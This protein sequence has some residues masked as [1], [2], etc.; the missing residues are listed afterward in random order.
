MIKV[1]IEGMPIMKL[2][3]SDLCK[4]CRQIR[5]T[6]DPEPSVEEFLDRF[7]QS[8]DRAKALYN[9]GGN[10]QTVAQLIWDYREGLEI[11]KNHLEENDGCPKCIGRI[12]QA[13][14]SCIVD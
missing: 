1:E 10:P 3:P 13:V 7:V 11:I 2:S 14:R 6:F 9:C 12:N 5:F 8:L 4:K